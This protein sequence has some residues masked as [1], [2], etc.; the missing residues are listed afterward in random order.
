MRAIG[1]ARSGAIHSFW[2]TLLGLQANCAVSRSRARSLKQLAPSALAVA[3][4]R[5]NAA[6]RFHAWRP[7]ICFLR[8]RSANHPSP[9][10]VHLRGEARRD[11]LRSPRHLHFK[12]LHTTRADGVRGRD[13]SGGTSRRLAFPTLLSSVGR[14]ARASGQNTAR[15]HWI[16]L[17][18]TKRGRSR[19]ED[20][21]RI[22]GETRA[23]D[24]HKITSHCSVLSAAVATASA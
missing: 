16:L 23:Y 22:R 11:F 4:G 21:I 7:R 24:A 8:F 9:L 15:T 6:V 2:G 14:T 12:H 17:S 19:L 5:R 18:A 20:S 13:V 10:S 3:I 1:G